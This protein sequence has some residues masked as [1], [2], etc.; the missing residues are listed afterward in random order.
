MF[1]DLINRKCTYISSSGIHYYATIFAIPPDCVVE[2][3]HLPVVS[4]RFID[5]YGKV[6][7][8]H[9]VEPRAKH[10]ARRCWAFQEGKHVHSRKY[11]HWQA[12]DENLEPL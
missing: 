9:R 12:Q 11:W 1:N 2:N 7:I 5:M 3:T 8:L 6:V 10:K 4:L